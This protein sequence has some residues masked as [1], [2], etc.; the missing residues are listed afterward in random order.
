MS[1]PLV[2][3]ALL[4]AIA[5]LPACQSVPTEQQAALGDEPAIFEF[6]DFEKEGVVYPIDVHDPIEPFNR[7]IYKF[8]AMFDRAI[9]VP[10]TELYEFVTPTFAQERVSDFFSNLSELNTFANSILQAKFE[11]ASRAVVR[12]VVNSTIG[13]AGLFD[14]MTALGTSQQ[15]ED[16]G[17]TLGVWGVAEGPYLVLPVLGP[18]N[19]RDT[20]GLIGDTAA[21]RAVDPFGLA[22]FESDHPEILALRAVDQ[23]H[24]VGLR[25]YETGS[26]FEYDLLRLLY[27]EKRRLD[28]AK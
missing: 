3:A 21:Y 7:A 20:V 26:P 9:F 5:V 15:R 4:L 27:T 8:N 19:L 25:Y 16:L 10:V 22:S 13:L 14:P 6:S 12:F 18:S 24:N 2:A 1:R 23:R 11:R 28:I 17:Q